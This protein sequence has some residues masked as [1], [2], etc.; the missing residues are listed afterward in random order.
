MLLNIFLLREV[1]VVSTLKFDSKLAGALLNDSWP[2]ILSG[3]VISIYMKIDQ[4]MIKEIL[5]ASPV[6]QYAAAARLSEAWYFI[7]VVICSSVFPALV[8]VRKINREL[9]YSRL[10]KLF[11]LMV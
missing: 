4:V 9:Y 1:P 11:D 3:I 8:N 7:P 5:G 6:G 10:Q 2:L